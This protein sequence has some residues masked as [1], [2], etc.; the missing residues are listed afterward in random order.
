[1][2]V[3]FLVSVGIVIGAVVVKKS[4][5][6]KN[7]SSNSSSPSSGVKF[8][9]RSRA[10]VPLTSAT[11]TTSSSLPPAKLMFPVVTVKHS[12]TDR[13][14]VGTYTEDGNVSTSTEWTSRRPIHI[15]HPTYSGEDVLFPPLSFPIH[16]KHISIEIVDDSG[17]T[18]N[19]YVVP[20]RERCNE[21]F[22]LEWW[23]TAASEALSTL[24][25]GDWGDG[26]AEK[27]K[28]D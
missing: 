15:P 20:E 10:V 13:I 24:S 6:A 12:D 21:A 26:D 18:I 9:G 14:F 16:T 19:R 5:G 17:V 8:I 7:G 1:M 27:D 2:L 3:F 4:L 23:P 28:K 25:T 22:S 11:N